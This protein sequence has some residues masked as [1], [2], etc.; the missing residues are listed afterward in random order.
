MKILHRYIIKKMIPP[1]FGGLGV[2]LFVLILDFLLDILNLVIAKG[3]PVLH[4][5]RLFAFSLASMISLAVPMASLL[6]ALMAYGGLAGDNEVVAARALGVPFTQMIIPGSFV[7]ILLSIVMIIFGDQVLP[8]ANLKAKT[9]MGQIHRKKPLTAI[10]PREFIDDFP[11]VVLYVDKVDDEMGKIFGV[12]LF[13][14][15]EGQIPRT[16]V[17]PEG[18]VK[19]IP[20]DDAISFILYDG[21]IHDVDFED[22]GR[23]TKAKFQKQVVSISD[24][25]TKLGGESLKKRGDRELSIGMIKDKITDYVVR[26]D[27]LRNSVIGIVQ[28][29]VDSLYIPRR[30]E[31]EQKTSP[32]RRALLTSRKRYSKLRNRQTAIDDAM[33]RK[34]KLEVEK[35]KKY[36]LPLACLVFLL[37]G[38]PVGVWAKKGGIGIA[39]GLA[40]GFFLLYWAFLIGGEE[41]ADRGIISPVLGMWSGNVLMMIFALAMI[42]RVTYGSRFSGYSWFSRFILRK[43]NE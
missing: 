24:L 17:A 26:I 1:F 3:V 13:E 8:E 35:H 40:F 15:R 4:V 39:T 33:R 16:I 7:M 41:I 28:R 6:S 21:E 38:A 23:Y 30:Y 14:K 12:K 25:G 27:T 31:R 11:G 34:R 36:S 29:A 9:L 10:H 32:L 18:E 5:G 19:Y 22:R 20:E 43:K 42:Y 37:V 2:I